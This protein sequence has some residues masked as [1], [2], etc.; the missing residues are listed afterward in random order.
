MI[1]YMN[2]LFIVIAVSL[3]GFGVGISYGMRKIRMSIT[4]LFIIMFCSG[5]IVLTS[6]S[7]GHVVRLFVSE[8]LTSM[9]GSIILIFLGLFVLFSVIRTKINEEKNNVKEERQQGKLGHFKSVISE[10]HRADK[11]QSGTISAP[12]ALILGIAL[13][14]DAFGAGFGAAM[15]GYSPIVTTILIASM[16]GI[17][18][19]SGMK[20]GY[21]LAKNVVVARLIYIPPILLICIGLYNLV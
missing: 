16:S 19:F 17:F 4:A 1:Y 8:K 3:D 11:D 7:I 15:L 5:F 6:M 20:I 21:L 2:L 14:L 12:E 18:V 10:P 9:F 13:A